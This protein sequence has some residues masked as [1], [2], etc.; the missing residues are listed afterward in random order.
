MW[1]LPKR[2]NLPQNKK[3]ELM[4][5]MVDGAGR[6][7][8]MVVADG[9]IREIA[10]LMGR[11]LGQLGRWA[12]EREGQSGK[13]ACDLLLDIVRRNIK[14][15][16]RYANKIKAKYCIIIGNTEIKEQKAK[17]KDMSDGTEF[18]VSLGDDFISEFLTVYTKREEA[19]KEERERTKI[20]R[21]AKLLAR[22]REIELEDANKS[23]HDIEVIKEEFDGRITGLVDE[24]IERFKK[25]REERN[26]NEE[27]S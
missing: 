22:I 26:N 6:D 2:K 23:K 17:I 1:F 14:P 24:A 9:D 12:A 7:C 8:P 3:H 13:V 21:H 4:V 16:L 27:Q 15:N 20:N 11:T 25:L 5:T 19:K 18:E 10:G